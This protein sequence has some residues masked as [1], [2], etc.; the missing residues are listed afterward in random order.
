MLLP[1]IAQRLH[2]EPL[3]I[4][5]ADPMISGLLSSAE[6]STGFSIRITQDETGQPVWTQTDLSEDSL[7]SVKTSSKQLLRASIAGVQ[8]EMTISQTEK[9]SKNHVDVRDKTTLIQSL[10]RM[11][12]V[13]ERFDSEQILIPDLAE[14]KRY[15]WNISE[16]G[17]VLYI[18]PTSSSGSDQDAEPEDNSNADAAA[19]LLLQ[20]SVIVDTPADT[21]LPASADIAG[22]A[23]A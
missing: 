8:L 16:S 5:L 14:G 3:E 19:E 7:F 18:E 17:P 1:M 20:D 4:I 21:Q 2:V 9:G 22:D 13:L 6:E 11:V 23:A 15:R 12:S 10:R